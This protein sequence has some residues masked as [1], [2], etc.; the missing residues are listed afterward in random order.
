MDRAKIF[1]A[2]TFLLT[3]AVCVSA[4]EQPPTIVWKN[5]Q[6][7]YERFEDVKPII[8]NTSNKLI[9]FNCNTELSL[10]F[11]NIKLFMFD[12]KYKGWTW[13]NMNCGYQTPKMRKSS[14]KQ[15]RKDEKLKQSGKYVPSGCKLNPNEEFM[16]SFSDSQWQDIKFG[17]VGP[18]YRSGKF[19]LQIIYSWYNSQM[20]NG[21]TTVDSPEF[22]VIPKENAK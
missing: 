9:Y 12:E 2:F 15:E 21:S 18:E 22:L 14:E 7:K 20:N 19:K 10:L 4:Q 13:N 5:L 1:I 16:F 11:G 8:V 6:E 3:F 17:P